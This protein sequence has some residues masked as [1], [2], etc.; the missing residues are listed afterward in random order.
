[1]SWSE[2]ARDAGSAWQTAEHY[3]PLRALN[4]HQFAFEYVRRNS[5]FPEK[6]SA[7]SS[8]PVNDGWLSG[9]SA[10]EYAADPDLQIWGLRFRH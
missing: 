3:E 7:L 1:M 8:R 2:R 4:R 5:H 10:V 6:E 9:A